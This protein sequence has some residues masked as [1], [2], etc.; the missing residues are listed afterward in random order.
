MAVIE[1]HR[2]PLWPGAQHCKRTTAEVYVSGLDVVGPFFF[3]G[4]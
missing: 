3:V 1:V 2:S 4:S